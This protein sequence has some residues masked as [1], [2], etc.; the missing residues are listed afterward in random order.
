MREGRRVTAPLGRKRR[1]G[2]RRGMKWRIRLDRPHDLR[3][4]LGVTGQLFG[5][6]RQAC[7]RQ[8][9]QRKLNE[10]TK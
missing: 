4:G 5:G 7:G 10:V 1:N 9:A 8:R 3:S 6:K 2:A